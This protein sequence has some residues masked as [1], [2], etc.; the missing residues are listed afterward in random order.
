MM[1][2]ILK[3]KL[4]EGPSPYLSLQGSDDEVSCSDSGNSSDSLNHPV[5]SGL[6]DS[7]LQQQSKRLRG[8]NV[9]FESVTV[10]Y[11]NR[12]QGFTSVPTQGGST[13]GMSPRHSGVKRFTLR[14]FAMEQK[15][16]HRNM[17]R[18]HLKE[19]KLNAIKL[20]LTK[21][22]T[23]PSVEADTLT[24]DDISE[25]DLDVDNTEVDDYFFLQPLTTRRRRALLRASGVRRL[26]VEEKHE[27]RALRM[28][29]EE[30]GCRCRGICDPVTCACS[31]AGIKCQVNGTVVDRM[32]FPCGCTKD[33]CS[34]DTGRLEFN[35]VR[36]RTHFLHTIM[37]LELE[38]SREE[39]QQQQQH[40]QPE[41]QLVTNG[42]GYHGDSS[43]V[44][45]Q[46]QQQPNLQFP[47]M[48]S[49]PHI[50]I[51]HLQS[52]GDTDSHLEEE[53][54]EE[55]EEEDE[56]EEDDEA[57][58]EDEDGS[59]VCSGLSDCSTHSLDTIDPEEE[60]EEEEDEED[61][62][63]DDD[64][65][66]DEDEEED[67]DC[68]L[69]GTSPP[70]YSVPL[71]SVLSYS[72]M[73]LSNPFHNTPSMQHYQID[74]AV[75]DT[76]AFLSENVTVAPTLPTLPT[77]ET[78]L[79]SEINPKLHCQTEQQSAPCHFPNHDDSQTPQTCSRVDPDERN[80]AP[81]G[82][83][84]DEQPLSIDLQNNLD[85]HD[86]QT[87]APAGSGKQTEAEI[88][89][90]IEEQP[91]PQKEGDADQTTETSCSKST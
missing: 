52:A 82:A 66:E 59:S 29:R 91:G 38:K 37:K 45:Q 44:Q 19:E 18:D 55:E 10:Y 61:E 70:P 36:V 39:Q 81:A 86:S 8:R 15:R 47:L 51:M 34:N 78:A 68:S 73:S 64:E 54:E 24:L 20:K 12:R 46:Q 48:S 6:L 50:P 57:Y 84:G 3:R 40:Q 22:G 53:E 28:S 5:P 62:E 79:K 49:T 1:S 30:C 9:H 21:N 60:E 56:D 42:N 77:V 72:N 90:P 23:V 63:D 31:L 27:L 75:N 83:S 26:E 88:T 41:Q 4:E 58:E 32:S 85:C 33:G 71:P 35:P 25:D 2:G 89:E 14:E 65:E 13:L 74:S 16:S 80:A 69:H 76:P 11:F 7:T 17:L 67:W 87:E 43:L